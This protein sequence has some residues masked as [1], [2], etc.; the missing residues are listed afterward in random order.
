[1]ATNLD[2]ELQPFSLNEFEPVTDYVAELFK[3]YREIRVRVLG[4]LAANS[5]KRAELANRFRTSKKM[6][7]GDEVVI[8][9]PRQRKAGGRTGYR[10][11]YTDPAQVVEVHG[12]KVTVKRKDGTLLTDIHTEDVMLV[13][14]NARNLEK[15]PLVFTPEDELTPVSYTHLTL[16]TICSV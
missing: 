14:K 1:M 15:E 11:P 8:R 13:P 5:E 10:Q 16:P 4:W 12:N 7:P 3:N 6:F 9:D 2:K